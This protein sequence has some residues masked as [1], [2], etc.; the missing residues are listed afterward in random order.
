MIQTAKEIEKKAIEEPKDV[1]VALDEAQNALFKISQTTSLSQYVLVADKLQGLTSSQDKPFLIQLQEKQEF[2]QQYA[3][4]GDALPISGIPT[5]F[6][7][8]DKMINGFS[9]SNLMILAAPR[10]C[11]GENCSCFKYRRKHVFSKSASH[12]NFFSRDDCRSANSQNH[13]LSI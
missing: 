2:F 7:D 13:M 8:L 6:I 10:T 11:Y 5:H 9:P 12:R 1:A 4:S 3:Q